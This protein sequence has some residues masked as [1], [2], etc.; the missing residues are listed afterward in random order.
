MTVKD[1]SRE[2]L[3]ALVQEAVEEALLELLGDPDR[4]L[5]LRDE[6]KKRLRH[7]LERV[8]KGEQGI[9]AEAVAKRAGLSW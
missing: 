5:E 3:K 6:I 9:S 8:Q 4:E 1:L 2:E 7:S